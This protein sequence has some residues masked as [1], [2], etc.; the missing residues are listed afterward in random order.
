M[1]APTIETNRLTLRAITRDDFEP[2]AKMWSDERVTTFI[3]GTPRPR[4][5]SWM[6][7]C[8]SVGFWPLFGFGYW[9]FVE[10]ATGTMIG[11]GGLAQFE[12]GINQLDGFPE[13]GWAFTAD[14]WGN[15]Y[16]SEAVAAIGAWADGQSVPEIRCIISP[17]N[18]PSIR[19]AEKNGF[20]RIDEVENEL[21]RSL[22]FS[23]LRS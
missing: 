8:Q 22:V 15:G 2:Y 23:R 19:V 12:R 10:R 18:T 5:V 3:G 1:I 9:L 21:G 16:A 11:L 6:K 4:D 17:E 14:S 20:A 13:A 7:F